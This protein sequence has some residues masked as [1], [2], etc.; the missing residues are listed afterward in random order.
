MDTKCY[1]CDT[2]ALSLLMETSDSVS[3]YYCKFCSHIQMG[4]DRDEILK[5]APNKILNLSKFV[6]NNRFD[7][8]DSKT[9]DFFTVK[10][11]ATLLKKSNISIVSIE[12]SG[13]FLE[14]ETKDDSSLDFQ[15][16]ELGDFLEKERDAGLGSFESIK[17]AADLYEYNLKEAF[18]YMEGHSKRA[19]LYGVSGYAVNMLN[20]AR[21]MGCSV[22]IQYAVDSDPELHDKHHTPSRLKVISPGALMSEASLWVLSS[23]P[24]E[25]LYPK[26]TF[27]G[28][29]FEIVSYYPHFHTVVPK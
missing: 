11:Y 27:S 3:Y 5:K 25:D 12:K 28:G 29:S 16:K 23:E 14:I 9:V 8:L 7:F 22:N 2:K 10:S 21:H 15:L 17:A 20:H 26:L 19:I 4:E 18:K 6:S 24:T 13:D 1:A